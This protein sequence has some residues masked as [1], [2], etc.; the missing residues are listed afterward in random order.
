MRGRTGVGGLRSRQ[1]VGAAVVGNVI[2]SQQ[3]RN[4]WIVEQSEGPA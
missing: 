1:E 2:G 3:A 4:E